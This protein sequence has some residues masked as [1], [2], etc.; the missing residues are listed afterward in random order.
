MLNKFSLVSKYQIYL[1]TQEELKAEIKKDVF[2]FG[3]M[4]EDNE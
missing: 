4:V 2:E 3:F 1:P